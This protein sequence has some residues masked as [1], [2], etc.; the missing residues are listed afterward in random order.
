MILTAHQP[1]YLPWLGL[2]HKIAISDMFVLLDEV[3]FEK[4]G[5][6]N[7]NKIKTKNESLL[8]TV[9]VLLKNYREIKSSEI[10]INN[11]TNWQR[12]H[13]SSIQMNYSQSPFFDDYIGFFEEVYSKKWN[14]LN[15]LN[16]YMLNWFL[17]KLE[18]KTKISKQSN[19]SFTGKKSDLILNMCKD[20][21]ASKFIFGSMG[22][23]Y[24]DVKSFEKNNVSVFFQE[25]VHPTYSQMKGDFIPNLSVLDLLFNHGSN[26]LEI[27]L[28]NNI[29]KF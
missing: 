3:Q 27:L 23:D 29:R 25:Y 7:R 1:V 13:L 19:Y 4:N 28:S 16:E 14:F 12:K 11:S 8:L 21:N 20:L 6:M 10:C 26:S 15:E 9:P 17:N 22:K 24:A 18:I 5:W 2:F